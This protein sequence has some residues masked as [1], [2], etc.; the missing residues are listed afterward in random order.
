MNPIFVMGLPRSGSTLLS[1]LLNATPDILSVNDLYYLQ[2]VL[3]EGVADLQLTHAVSI[4]LIDRLL[5]VIATRAHAN[6]D[7]IGQFD[8]SPEQLEEIR[9]AVMAAPPPRW[10][11]LLDAVLSRVAQA[12]GKRRWADKT[13]Q[14]FYHLERLAVAFP[15]ARFVFLFRDPRSVLASFKYAAGDGHDPRRYHPVVYALYWRAAVRWWQRFEGDSR[16]AMVRYEDLVSNSLAA[17]AQL[18]GFLI[19]HIEVQP[20]DRIGHN[21]S[22]AKGDRQT[23]SPTETWICE[24]FCRREMGVLG[25]QSSGAR[26][27]IRGIAALLK[28]SLRFTSFQLVRVVRDR[29]AR[30][31]VVAYLRGLRA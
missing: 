1:R 6:E 15:D 21:S 12:G 22:F 27:N 14:N 18:S 8:I 31:R 4:R 5:E 7:F 28:T 23:L 29:D 25:Y 16:V 13:P 26:P 9:S 17:C 24:R 30:Q 3:A 2:A 11:L 10:N 20:L 19:T